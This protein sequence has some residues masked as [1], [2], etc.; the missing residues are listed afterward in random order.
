VKNLQERPAVQVISFVPGTSGASTEL[1]E[2]DG[3]TNDYK[4]GEFS[5]RTVVRENTSDRTMKITIAPSIGNYQGMPDK[6]AFELKLLNSLLPLSVTINGE[7][8]NAKYLNAEL[9]STI[10]IPEMPATEK[11]EVLI[12]FDQSFAEQLK[13]LDGNKG[14]LKR[15][16]FVTEKLKFE[17]AA[18]DWGGTLPNDIYKTGNINNQIVYHPEQVF[19]LMQ[20]L[21][22]LKA[23]ISDVILSIPDIKQDKAQAMIEYLGLKP[24]Q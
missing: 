5:K 14:F 17:V 22:K 24:V 8:A 12:V 3:N 11:I 15:V 2:D 16:A 9:A 13:A 18:V 4:L 1:Y 7:A 20:S 23:F 10:I 21:N 6:M 19:T